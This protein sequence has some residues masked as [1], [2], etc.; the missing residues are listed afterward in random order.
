MNWKLFSLAALC[1]AACCTSDADAGWRHRNR[2][3]PQNGEERRYLFE[4]GLTQ[5]RPF[6]DGP[7]ANKFQ[8]GQNACDC[9]QPVTKQ[10]HY[11]VLTISTIR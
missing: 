5:G 4:G 1:M 6:A 3:C 10:T 11:G 8:H 7:Y 2:N 9:Q